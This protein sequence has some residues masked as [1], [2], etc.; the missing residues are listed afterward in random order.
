MPSLDE[1]QK[2]IDAAADKVSS[3]FNLFLVFEVN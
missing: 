1:L 3:P 2:V